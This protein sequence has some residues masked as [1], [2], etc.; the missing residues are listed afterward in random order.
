MG[1]GNNTKQVSCI[2]VHGWAMN[3]AVWDKCQS[4]LPDWIDALFVDLPGHGTM[5][6]VM[7]DNIDDYVQALMPLAHRPVIWVGWSLGAL[8]VIRLAE[9]YPERVASLFLVAAT[10]CFVERDDWSTAV[11]RNTFEQFALS[12]AQNQSKTLTRFLTLQMAGIKD[13]REQVRYLQKRMQ[14]RGNASEAA[15]KAGL[16]MLVNSDYRETVKKLSCPLSWYL[17]G[18]DKLI[19]VALADSL[20]E[21]LS[22][23]DITVQPSAGHAPFLSHPEAFIASLVSRAEHFRQSDTRF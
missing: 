19:P 16:D 12:L 6:D 14:L 5:V 2:F 18:H 11:E 17:G 22:Q 3:S 23:Q 4:L 10:P 15:L 8:A 21:E 9:L 7:A 20:R 1:Q 13:A